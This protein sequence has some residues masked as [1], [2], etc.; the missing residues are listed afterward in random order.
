MKLLIKINFYLGYIENEINKFLEKF[1][2][3]N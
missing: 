1:A 2:I 3:F